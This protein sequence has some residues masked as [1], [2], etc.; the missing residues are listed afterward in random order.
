MPSLMTLK[1][2]LPGRQPGSF[3]E[4]FYSFVCLLYLFKNK[5]NKVGNLKLFSKIKVKVRKMSHRRSGGVLEL[6]FMPMETLVNLVSLKLFKKKNY[7]LVQTHCI[8]KIKCQGLP[9]GCLHYKFDM[10]C[11]ETETF[12]VVFEFAYFTETC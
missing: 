8:I 1:K 6:L 4:S 7:S 5:K 9:L 2:A 10:C 3:R 11:A 12:D